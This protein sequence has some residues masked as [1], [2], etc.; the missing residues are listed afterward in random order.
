MAFNDNAKKFNDQFV[1]DFTKEKGIQNPDITYRIRTDWETELD[2]TQ[3]F[4]DF[5]NDPNFS[6]IDNF[7]IGLW[8]L[9]DSTISPSEIMQVILD[10]KD[11]MQHI[12]GI[13]FGDIT[14]E[15]NEVSWIENMNHGPL[16]QALPNLETYQVRGGNNL[17]LGTDLKH[18]NLKKLIIETGGMSKNILNEIASADLPKLTH[19]ELWLGDEG[20]GFDASIEDITNAYRGHQPDHLPSLKY[21]GLRNSEVA[22]EIAV[23]LIDDPVFD[24]I[25]VLDLSKGTLGNEGA[26]AILK[27]PSILKL[28]KMDLHHNYISDELAAKIGALGI[29]INLDDREPNPGEYDRYVEVGE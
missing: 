18:P 4:K 13:F 26:E 8:V 14:Y 5:I 25:E 27:N 29:E 9:D 20:Y 28:Q 12:K 10:N 17:S 22:D 1:K 11:K 6:K 23:A 16:L 2:A 21:L 7:I 3:L 19:L 24:K 15:E